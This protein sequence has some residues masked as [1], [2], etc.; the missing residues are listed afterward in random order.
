M[1]DQKAVQTVLQPVVGWVDELAENLVML[2]VGGMGKRS[3]VD[4]VVYWV[5]LTVVVLVGTMDNK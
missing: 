3:A 1:V 4:L 5:A 2:Q